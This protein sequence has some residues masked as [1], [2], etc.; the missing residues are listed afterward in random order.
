MEAVGAID[1]DCRPGVAS[2]RVDAQRQ[3]VMLFITLVIMGKLALVY[4][5]FPLE[6]EAQLR[7]NT[8]P[9]CDFSVGTVVF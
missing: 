7:R 9:E 1:I 4:E 5:A 2:I 8:S 3:A 6:L